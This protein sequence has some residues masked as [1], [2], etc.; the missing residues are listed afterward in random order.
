MGQFIWRGQL[1]WVQGPGTGA[2]TILEFDL[3]SNI[4]PTAG[5]YKTV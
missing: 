1:H 3:A 2:G 4:L 5:I